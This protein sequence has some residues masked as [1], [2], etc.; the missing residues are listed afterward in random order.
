MATA[1][2]QELLIKTFRICLSGVRMILRCSEQVTLTSFSPPK[3]FFT[4][5]LREMIFS[6]HLQSKFKKLARSSIG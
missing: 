5:L 4:H 2:L 1:S 3:T 6:L